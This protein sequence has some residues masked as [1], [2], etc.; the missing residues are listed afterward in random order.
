MS[1]AYRISQAENLQKVAHENDRWLTSEMNDVNMIMCMNYDVSK[2]P[3]QGLH[4]K[5]RVMMH[6]LW[7]YKPM[8]IE[9]GIVYFG[10]IMRKAFPENVPSSFY[11]YTCIKFMSTTNILIFWFSSHYRF[12][13]GLLKNCWQNYS[14]HFRLRTSNQLF[15]FTKSTA[16]TE[17]R[18]ENIA[19]LTGLMQL[20]WSMTK[21][22]KLGSQII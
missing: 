19:S 8:S 18:S 15:L 13:Y 9:L 11:H 5:K 21:N 16:D 3:H 4:I 20:N 12:E 22:V 10:Y 17:A 7:I 6:V 2:R 1:C 14:L